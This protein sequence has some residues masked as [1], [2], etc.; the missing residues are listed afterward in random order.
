MDMETKNL[1]NKTTVVTGG[2]C[3]LRVPLT[4]KAELSQTNQIGANGLRE[5]YVRALVAA[6]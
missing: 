3:S 2:E 4:S 5:A 6:G 1:K